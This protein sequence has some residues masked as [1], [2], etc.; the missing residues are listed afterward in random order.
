[1]QQ[2]HQLLLRNAEDFHVEILRR[3]AEDAIANEPADAQRASAGVTNDGGETR[4]LLFQI[5]MD[6]I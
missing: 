5:H 1:L 6:S 3:A 4:R 2:R